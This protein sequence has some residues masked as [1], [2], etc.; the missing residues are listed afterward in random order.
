MP[1]EK[2]ARAQDA[3]RSLLARMRHTT[4]VCRASQTGTGPLTSERLAEIREADARTCGNDNGYFNGYSMAHIDRHDL[5]RHIDAT[6]GT[7]GPAAARERPSDACT[8][9]GCT[10]A[11][12][13]EGGCVPVETTLEI[14]L[15]SLCAWTIARDAITAGI[16]TPAPDGAL[17]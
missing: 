7:P 11:E 16:Y 4:D 6:T 8:V 14:S 17:F 9:C 3:R 12:P 1:G 15:C 10:P 2:D 5:L 13:C